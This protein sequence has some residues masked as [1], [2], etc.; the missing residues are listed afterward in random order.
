[1]MTLKAKKVGNNNGPETTKSGELLWPYI[2]KS[3][4]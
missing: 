4:E 2:P 3:G 1:M